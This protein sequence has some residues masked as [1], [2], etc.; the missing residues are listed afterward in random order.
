MRGLFRKKLKDFDEKHE[1]NWKKL[2]LNSK[3]K[4]GVDLTP[5]KAGANYLD[6]MTQANLGSEH[7]Y[8]TITART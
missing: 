7:N 1:Q 4:S 2:A 3:M 8:N 6:L 5:G